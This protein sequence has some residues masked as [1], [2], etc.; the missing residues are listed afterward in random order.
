MS[1]LRA[2]HVCF[3]D[4][5]PIHGTHTEKLRTT[6]KKTY[7]AHT[8]PGHVLN[9]HGTYSEHTW[10]KYTWTIH[11]HIVTE[12]HT[13]HTWPSYMAILWR[14]YTRTIH[15]HHTWPSYTDHTWPSYMAIIHG[16]HT[17]TIHGRHVCSM[18]GPC[19]VSIRT[20]FNRN[21]FFGSYGFTR[22]MKN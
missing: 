20:Y 15:G 5:W 4:T 8:W 22:F 3:F 19:I 21:F 16:H 11:G 18:Y 1:W 12:I 17:R 6:R 7:M 14:K 9:T 2:S 13:D 10:P